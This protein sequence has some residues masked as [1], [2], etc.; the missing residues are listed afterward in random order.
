MLAYAEVLGGEIRFP[1][2]AMFWTP[3]F[4]VLRDRW[5]TLWMVSVDGKAA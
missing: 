4:G 3:G 5:G 2:Q 1:F